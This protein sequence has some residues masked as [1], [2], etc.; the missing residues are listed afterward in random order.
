MPKRPIGEIRKK[1]NLV[2]RVPIKYK[3]SKRQLYALRQPDGQSA[4]SG[5]QE[6]GC[7]P[8]AGDG[9]LEGSFEGREPVETDGGLFLGTTFQ[10]TLGPAHYMCRVVLRLKM[11]AT[12]VTLAYTSVEARAQVSP[13]FTLHFSKSFRYYKSLMLP[14]IPPGDKNQEDAYHPVIEVRVQPGQ[15][16]RRVV[17]YYPVDEEGVYY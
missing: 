1:S 16:Y 7:K 17:K 11:E 6:D 12:D 14:Q 13:I 3:T 2:T 4:V 15:P 10:P 5:V 9:P 8:R